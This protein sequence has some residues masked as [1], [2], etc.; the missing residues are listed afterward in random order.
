MTMRMTVRLSAA[1]AAFVLP[2]MLAAPATASHHRKPANNPTK[3]QRPANHPTKMRRPA[4]HP[5]KRRPANHPTK[6]RPPNHPT[7]QGSAAQ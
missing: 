3:M 6:R 1:V 7:K 4:H 5:T 2:M